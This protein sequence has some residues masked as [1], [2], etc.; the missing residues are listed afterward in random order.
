[1]RRRGTLALERRYLRTASLVHTV[2]QEDADL[3]RRVNPSAKTAVVPIVSIGLWTSGMIGQVETDSVPSIL[4][5]GDLGAP[6][7]GRASGR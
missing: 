3:L 6:P 7:Y 4:I 5:G 2:T 1:M